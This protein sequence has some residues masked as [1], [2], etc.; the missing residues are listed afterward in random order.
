VLQKCLPEDAAN[1]R[2]SFCGIGVL[3]VF[4]P[5]QSGLKTRFELIEPVPKHGWF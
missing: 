2:L 1:N 5:S 3:V 4:R